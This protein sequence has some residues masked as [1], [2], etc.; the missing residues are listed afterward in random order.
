MS[1]VESEAPAAMAEDSPGALVE[2]A[3]DAH[4]TRMAYN[5]SSRIPWWVVVVWA[6]TI[7]GFVTYLVRYLFPDLSQW[8][9][10]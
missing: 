1:A 5:E 9:S 3:G 2:D 7:I 6:I 4:E 10:P 8:G